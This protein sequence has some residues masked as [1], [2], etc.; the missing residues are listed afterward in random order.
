MD[1]NETQGTVDQK[2]FPVKSDAWS[3]AKEMHATS[4]H[5][6][7]VVAAEA[8]GPGYQLSLEELKEHFAAEIAECAKA[9]EAS[10]AE[11]KAREDAKAAK[12]ALI[13]SKP[14]ATVPVAMLGGKEGGTVPC[15]TCGFRFTPYGW[16]KT[17][18]NKESGQSVIVTKTV[19]IKGE[20]RV[21]EIR[22]GNFFGWPPE[23]G[24]PGLFTVVPLCPDHYERGKKV[25]GCDDKFIKSLGRDAQG[26][27]PA[28][29]W[30]VCQR[31]YGDLTEI[32][33][34]AVISISVAEKRE[35]L[36]AKAAEAVQ[37]AEER[38]ERQEKL[39]KAASRLTAQHLQ[40]L[41]KNPVRGMVNL[42]RRR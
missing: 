11:E 27:V 2:K 4:L 41:V 34:L 40:V 22:E 21:L 7:F 5:S 29:I 6:K 42:N 23:E 15:K 20:E 16:R 18:F 32:H 13:D 36:E 33:R 28:E 3:Y 25:Q 10:S 14:D 8:Q 39:L 1:G 26:R 30:K 9:Y 24:E 37:E 12:K 31:T 17:R 19:T 35:R 38:Q